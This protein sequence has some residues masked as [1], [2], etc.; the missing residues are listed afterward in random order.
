MWRSKSL[1]VAKNY[2]IR[3][4]VVMVLKIL[5]AIF[6]SRIERNH[7]KHV[8]RYLL[9]ELNATVRGALRLK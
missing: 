8:L 5:R 1:F 7:L 9:P 3:F 4:V 2:G 6:Q